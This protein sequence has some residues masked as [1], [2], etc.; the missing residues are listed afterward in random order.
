[1][2]EETHFVPLYPCALTSLRHYVPVPLC[3]SYYVLCHFFCALMSVFVKIGLQNKDTV[4]E[5]T[6]CICNVI[7]LTLVFLCLA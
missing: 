5:L 7:T 6:Y 3:L 1:M 2:A 4:N